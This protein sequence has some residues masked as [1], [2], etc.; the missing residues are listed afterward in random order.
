M[1]FYEFLGFD[2]DR[3]SFEKVIEHQTV[4][5]TRTKLQLLS[6]L[7]AILPTR[8]ILERRQVYMFVVAPLEAANEEGDEWDGTIR[9]LTRVVEG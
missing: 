6:D 5:A 4:N 7:T 1:H 3:D 2:T 8:D 9:R